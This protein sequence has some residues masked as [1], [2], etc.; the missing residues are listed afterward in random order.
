MVDKDTP[1]GSRKEL[2]PEGV[3][4]SMQTPLGSATPSPNM[5]T[6]VD[7]FL[8]HPEGNVPRMQVNFN[9]PEQRGHRNAVD[10]PNLSGS[11]LTNEEP[12]PSELDD[13]TGISE[14]DT[15]EDEV[16]P[17]SPDDN[18]LDAF[19]KYLQ[20]LPDSLTPSERDK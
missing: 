17:I 19:S 8:M 2:A 11:D 3:R 6:G 16:S 1:A 7:A 4:F 10:S 13:F 20:K 18:V 15:I 14:T 9:S 5:A 12:T